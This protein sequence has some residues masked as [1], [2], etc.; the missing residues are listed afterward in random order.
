MLQTHPTSRLMNWVVWD[1]YALNKM[2]TDELSGIGPSWS[3][4]CYQWRLGIE[5]VCPSCILQQEVVLAIVMLE[6][7]R[8][9]KRFCE[10][11]GTM[12]I[13]KFK[14]VALTRWLSQNT[15]KQQCIIITS[16]PNFLLQ[17]LTFEPIK[18][19]SKRNLPLESRI[20]AADILEQ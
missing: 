12:N 6:E 16:F 8:S 9:L 1:L 20:N 13:T 11:A 10:Q 17:F 5:Y 7:P 19:T 2:L 15:I 14:Y 3:R 18:V 4:L